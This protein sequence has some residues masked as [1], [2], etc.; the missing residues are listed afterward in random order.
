MSN[1]SSITA[2]DSDN[3]RLANIETISDIF[4]I[5]D[6]DAIEVARV[7]GW[8]VVVRKNEFMV[9]DTVIYGEVD[10][11]LPIADS[12]FAFLAPRGTKTLENGTEGH[13]LKTVRLRGQYS[14][15]IIFAV[16]DFSEVAGLPVGEDVTQLLGITK[17]EVP[18]PAELAGVAKGY[19]PSWITKSSEARVQN[20]AGILDAAGIDG[21]VA[22]EKIDGQSTTFFI[23][24]DGTFGVATRNTELLYDANNKLW[25]KAA[26]LDIEAKLRAEFDGHRAVVQGELW[27]V[28][29][30]QNPLRVND[31]RFNSFAFWLDGVEV[32]RDEWPQWVKTLS[33][34][35]Y[36]NL[37]FPKALD[38]ANEQVESLKSLVAPERAAEGVVWRNAKTPTVMVNGRLERAS[39]KV[40]SR[41]YLTKN[42]G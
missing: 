39:F 42:G 3:R 23:E 6:A 7:R 36:E 9:G 33:V 19:M 18:L 16:T 21:W 13:V 41:R 22:S 38:E 31:V 28:G 12:R 34:P 40:I 20:F 11:F 25:I 29:I 5:P 24:K 30:S 27:G 17:Y 14:Q 32:P 15:G 2:V 35:I 10:S 8:D 26:E 1:T 37:T 4:P